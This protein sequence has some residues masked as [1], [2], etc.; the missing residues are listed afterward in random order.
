VFIADRHRAA[1]P[2][3][4]GNTVQE[5]VAVLDE[6][7]EVAEERVGFEAMGGGFLLRQF[8]CDDVAGDPDDRKKDG[9]RECFEMQGSSLLLLECYSCG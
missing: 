6:R 5:A 2:T 3:A 4:G 1:S 7:Q 8:C 9:R